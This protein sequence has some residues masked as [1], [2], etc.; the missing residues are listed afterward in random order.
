MAEESSWSWLE[1]LAGQVVEVGGEALK[2]KYSAP[3]ND[4][5]QP[6]QQTVTTVASDASDRGAIQPPGVRL[7]P[8]QWAALAVAAVLVLVLVFKR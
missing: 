8:W 4:P 1:G 2:A 7:Q 3:S 5:D 6:V